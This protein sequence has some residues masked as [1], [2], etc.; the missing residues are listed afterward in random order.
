LVWI[1][2][3]GD[4]E[5]T[6]EL[7][8]F[9]IGPA[10]ELALRAEIHG[11]RYPEFA[12]KMLADAKISYRGWIAN[13]KAPEAFAR[14]RLTVHVPRRPYVRSLRGI[15]TIRVFEALACGIPLI[16]APWEDAENLFTPGED[17]LVA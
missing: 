3:W 7:Q 10:R 1:G 13:F 6:E 12:L 14:A 11:V 16:S 4:D 15:P 2:N 8:E 9:L 5:R 17:F